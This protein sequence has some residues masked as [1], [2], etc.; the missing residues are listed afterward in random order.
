M[1]MSTGTG[2]SREPRLSRFLL[3]FLLGFLKTTF[4]CAAAHGL[5]H[6]A[7]ARTVVKSGHT[8]MR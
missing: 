4:M 3:G 7:T 2:T 5:N 1:S 8:A 6:A